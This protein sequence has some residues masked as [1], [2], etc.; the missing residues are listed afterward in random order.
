MMSGFNCESLCN[1]LFIAY[2]KLPVGEIAMAAC[3]F[4]GQTVNT[5]SDGRS[6]QRCQPYEVAA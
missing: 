2:E 1:G 3:T 6:P 5:S 4:F